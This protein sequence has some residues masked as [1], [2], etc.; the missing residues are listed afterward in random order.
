[1]RKSKHG[2]GAQARSVSL[3]V[4][5]EYLRLSP[6]TVSLVINRSKAAAAIPHETQQR[7]FQGAKKLNYRPN[8]YARSLRTRRSFTIGILH[9]DLSD[10]VALLTSGVEDHLMGEG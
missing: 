8:F 7:I 4:L 6:A 1:M 10:Y 3:K 5:A 9:P 2:K